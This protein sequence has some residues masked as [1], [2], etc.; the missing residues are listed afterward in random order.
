[1]ARLIPETPAGK[2]PLAAQ[3]AFRFFKNLPDD[4]RIWHHLAPWDPLAPDFLLFSPAGQAL[5]V[6]VSDAS[7]AA[8]D[9]AAQLTL[10][11]R[12]ERPLGQ[13]E[14]RLL[15]EFAARLGGLPIAQIVLFPNI[16][17][18]H[19]QHALAQAPDGVVWWGQEA[20][21]RPE[22]WLGGLQ[23]PGLDDL[24]LEKLRLQFTPEAA[25]PAALTVRGPAERRLQAGLTDYLLDY[26]QEAALKTDL[27]LDAAG[28][29][30]AKELQT[31]LI[32]GVAGN[33][34]T[35]I[36]LYR[37]RLLHEFFPQK[38]FLVL[39]HNRP[40][41][42]DLQQR[43]RRLTG[44][45]PDNIEWRTFYGWCRRCWPD[46][47]HPWLDPIGLQKR[48]NTARAV[49]NSANGKGFSPEM[50]LSELDWFKDQGLESLEEYLSA[51]R[52]GRGFRLSAEQRRRLAACME[53]YQTVLQARNEVEWGDVPRWLWRWQSEKQIQLPQ[54]DVILID[55]AQFFAPIWFELLLRAITPHGHLFIAADPTQ[56][57]LGRGTSWKSVGLDV[58]GR[59]HQLQHSYRTTREILSFATLFFRQRQP[60]DDPEEDILTADL[61]DMPSGVLPML[62]VLERPQ[63]EIARIA[64]E[65]QAMVQ[66]GISPGHILALHANWQGVEQLLFALRARLGAEAAQDAKDCP[67]GEHVRVTTL[68]AGTGLES[69]F[70]FLA[71]LRQLF[72]QEQSLRISEDEREKLVRENTRKVYMAITRAGQRLVIA[73]A[74]KLPKDLA[75]MF[76]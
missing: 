11:G 37:L 35:L 16:P 27:D 47:K 31:S 53:H 69:P 6:K 56:G 26:D 75:R 38:R 72:E 41:M 62:L 64:N 39:T 7:Q 34:K 30:T 65:I 76:G 22:R 60:D 21:H 10:L 74:G 29:R 54:Y 8:A 28:Q 3:R 58:R 2:I 4:W 71:G 12:S 67:P 25:V 40:L 20:L 61:L 46:A 42:L 51:D 32:N 13:E 57:F 36:L 44:R 70:V 48:Q 68:N 15:A 59:S 63:D 23:L 52:R 5:L 43:Y 24:A 50:L 55:E 9:A 19:L 73:Y 66:Q 1:M 49:L 14:S 17:E 33:G 45:L 18:K